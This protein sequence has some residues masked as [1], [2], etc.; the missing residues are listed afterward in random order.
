MIA[1]VARS[2]L[3][4]LGMNHAQ[5]QPVAAQGHN[6]GSSDKPTNGSKRRSARMAFG[7]EE[8]D[9]QAAGLK[10]KK[11]K[12]GE[13]GTTTTTKVEVKDKSSGAAPTSGKKAVG[14]TRGKKCEYMGY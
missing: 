12:A 5:A 11:S 1:L 13:I 4:V 8:E 3:Q 6:D 9:A 10:S 7:D 2:P 14:R